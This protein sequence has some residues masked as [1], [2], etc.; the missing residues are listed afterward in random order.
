[1]ATSTWKPQRQKRQQDR[2]M[3]FQSLMKSPAMS[4][5]RQSLRPLDHRLWDLIMTNRALD[6]WEPRDKVYGLLGIAKFEPGENFRVDYKVPVVRLANTILSLHHQSD[7]K[8]TNTEMVV[9]QCNQLADAFGLETGRIYDKVYKEGVDELA[10]VKNGA[11]CPLGDPTVRGVTLWWAW[12]YR[13]QA[14]ER[15]L[16]AADTDERVI[17]TW[18]W[19]AEKGEAAIV[20]M[21]LYHDRVDPYT[22]LW[23]QPE[24]ALD[25][26]ALAP[27]VDALGAACCYGHLEVVE[28]LMKYG[29]LLDGEGE[30]E[31]DF[32]AVY[33]LPPLC[34]AVHGTTSRDGN[35]DIVRFL[36]EKGVDPNASQ[37]GVFSAIG[38]AAEYG[39]HSLV[40]LL[41]EAGADVHF[42]NPLEAVARH[43]H[44]AVVQL[45]I[46]NGADVNDGALCSASL[47]GH[48][49]TVRLLLDNGAD[50]NASHGNM[51]RPLWVAVNEAPWGRG[52]EAHNHETVMGLLIEAGAD[53]NA[54]RGGRH[55]TA[56]IAACFKLGDADHVEGIRILLEAGAETGAGGGFDSALQVASLYSPA[57][58]RILLQ[59]GADVNT[60]GSAASRT[61]LA[62]KWQSEA[63]YRELAKVLKDREGIFGTALQIASAQGHVESIRLL[64]A[65]GAETNTPA[66]VTALGV[67]S[68]MGHEEAV[69]LL[70][71][72]GAILTEADAI[73]LE[74]VSLRAS[75]WPA[76]QAMFPAA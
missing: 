15:L 22:Q 29:M 72:A 64:L 8:L 25:P 67:A 54:D 55:G 40:Q 43:G 20:R 34:A 52:H 59:W 13:H 65:A 31:D 10:N 44:L 71:D 73:A 42:G 47:G 33:P 12:F 23:D 7:G 66:S 27:K 74:Q 5:V 37:S 51:G 28:V 6:C 76:W 36:L 70:A 46:D 53:P 45:L 58:L 69:R 18:K 38:T 57:A 11:E 39:H 14:V 16:V 24:P 30:D 68:I 9:A 49:E 2:N 50:P 56:L 60:P 41:I 35:L 62:G 19:A 75:K 1:M 63:P 21:L 17:L 61:W 3:D 26:D 32:W 48:V 4:I